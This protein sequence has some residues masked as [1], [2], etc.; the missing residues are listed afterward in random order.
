MANE[1]EKIMEY[2][3]GIPCFESETYLC[4]YLFWLTGS[5][6]NSKWTNV[7]NQG[8]VGNK[9]DYPSE[10]DGSKKSC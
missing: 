4:F 10:P 9:E 7:E 8:R 6:M 1:A 3:W 2:S 5:R